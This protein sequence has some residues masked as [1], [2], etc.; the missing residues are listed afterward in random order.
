M[1]KSIAFTYDYTYYTVQLA[2][3]QRESDACNDWL[4]FPRVDLAYA[5][6]MERDMR[7]RMPTSQ[8][9]LA[10]FRADLKVRQYAKAIGL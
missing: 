9:M 10:Q 6:A 2:Q 3:A 5:K 4:G 7:R 8:E 1:S